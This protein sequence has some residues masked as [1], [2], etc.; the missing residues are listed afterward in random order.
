M[1]KPLKASENDYH[2]YR[3]SSAEGESGKSW[4]AP[5]ESVTSHW[6]PRDLFE[7]LAGGDNYHLLGIR[8]YASEAEALAALQR[9]RG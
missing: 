7:R 9:A 2:W 8:R 3:Q 5:G 4:N 1:N 6:L